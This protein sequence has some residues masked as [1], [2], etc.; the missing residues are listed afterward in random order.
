M[1][2]NNRLKSEEGVKVDLTSLKNI[3]NNNTAPFALNNARIT[4][5]KQNLQQA[6]CPPFESMQQEKISLCC[7][8]GKDAK[9]SENANKSDF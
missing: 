3:Y 7:M 5:K 4:Y 2:L 1:T 9:P 6:Q 8:M